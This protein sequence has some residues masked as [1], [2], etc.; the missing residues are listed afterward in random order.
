MTLSA[1]LTT[2]M[3]SIETQG[4][5]GQYDKSQSMIKVH[6]GI[7]GAAGIAIGEAVVV[8]STVDLSIIFL[9]KEEN[10]QLQLAWFNDA[11][12]NPLADFSMMKRKLKVIISDNSLDI[13]DVY[14]QL[15]E[16]DIFKAEIL[17]KIQ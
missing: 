2:A 13:F 11:A 17:N 1:Q 15:L 4:L 7:G 10:S 8:L 16:S 6:K 5:M 3:A 12:H 14:K 9:V